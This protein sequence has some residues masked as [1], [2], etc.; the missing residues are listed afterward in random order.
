MGGGGEEGAGHRPRAT[1]VGEKKAMQKWMGWGQRQ[2]KKGLEDKKG[3]KGTAKGPEGRGL[4]R[5][6]PGRVGPGAGL[7]RGREYQG[8]G[9]GHP[10]Q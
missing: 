6:T 5:E 1:K 10:W 7:K 9:P 3:L 2:R 8:F 4:G